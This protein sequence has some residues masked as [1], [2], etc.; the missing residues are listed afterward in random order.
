MNNN[1]D[2]FNLDADDLL[3]RL[4]AIFIFAVE[5]SKKFNA[6][7][8]EKAKR[9]L[10]EIEWDIKMVMGWSDE[11]KSIANYFANRLAHYHLFVGDIIHHF[12]K[13]DDRSN[14]AKPWKVLIMEDI[15]SEIPLTSPGYHGGP[16][17]EYVDCDGI[18]YLMWVLR[19]GDRPMSGSWSKVPLG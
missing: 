9:A 5:G 7:K 11:K 13:F 6:E 8:S 2:R 3:D 4:I 14:R 16:K 18:E 17:I 19:V 12:A 10:D 15:K 1:E